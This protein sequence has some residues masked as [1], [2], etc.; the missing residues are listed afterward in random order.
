MRYFI[1]ILAFLFVWN[2]QAALP[3]MVKGQSDS[4][5]SYT[6]VLQAPYNQMTKLSDRQFLLETGNKNLFL[7][8]SFEATPGTTSWTLGS[9]V[10]ASDETSILKD[11][12]KS[13]HFTSSVAGAQDIIS[14]RVIPAIDTTSDSLLVYIAIKNTA[15][16]LQ[17][18]ARVN[19]TDVQCSALDTT[20]VWKYYSFYITHTSVLDQLGIAIESTA[21][22]TLATYVDDSGLKQSFPGSLGTAV[23]NSSWTSAGP[24]T[25]TATT[26]NPTKGTTS[27]D[28][29]LWRQV[30]SNLEGRIEFSQTTGGT[31]GSGDY[32]FAIPSSTGC[33]IDSSKV[34]FNSTV[35]GNSAAPPT[36]AV[37][38]ASAGRASVAA[39]GGVTS[40]YD[41]THLRLFVS[42]TS[43]ALYQ[44]VGSSFYDES[45]ANQGYAA[46]FSVP[47]VGWAGTQTTFSNYIGLQSWSGTTSYASASLTSTSYTGFTVTTPAITT[48]QSSNLSPANTASGV[49][50]QFT[51]TEAG[52]YFV[53]ATST[54]AT[55]GSSGLSLRMVDEAST[56]INSGHRTDKTTAADT[57]FTLCGQK[58]VTSISTTAQFILQG[59]A[60]SGTETLSGNVDWTIFKLSQ[61]FPYP[62]FIGS[63]V[64]NTTGILDIETGYTPA[65]TTTPCPSVSSTNGISNITRSGTGTYSINYVAGTFSKS[66]GCVVSPDDGGNNAVSI[67]FGTVST[68]LF[69]FSIRNQSGTAQDLAFTFSCSGLK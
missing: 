45:G 47:C 7:N 26:T 68:S 21:A 12:K 31:A 40:V 48:L 11:G 49:G 30:G 14:Q 55:S 53:C 38:W 35:G 28:R 24:N 67:V 37:G 9:G 29:F 62:K 36:N 27:V 17:V 59:A 32:L 50:V 65:C 25:I 61:N 4:S 2:A 33:T 3:L 19:S 54:Q 63:V 69:S 60:T 5:R 16:N 10:T 20:G 52:L 39:G 42:S 6:E 22:T 1:F 13:L 57:T 66:F 64:S 23:P 8:P 43:V 15:S 34:T 41:S 44:A 58:L 51:P 46:G 56:V 18:C